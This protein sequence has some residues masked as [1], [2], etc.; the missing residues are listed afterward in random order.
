M[1]YAI[2]VTLLI[3]ADSALD[4][5]GIGYEAGVHLLDTFNDDESIE[6]KGVSDA[7]PEVS[8]EE[9]EAHLNTLNLP[10]ALWWFI[11]NINA[12][13]PHSTELFFYLRERVRGGA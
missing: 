12:D 5:H 13:D 2:A 9:R 3:E 7:L 6:V 4:A 8:L 1:K 10:E 11:E